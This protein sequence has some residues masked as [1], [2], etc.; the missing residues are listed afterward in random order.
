MYSAGLKSL[1]IPHYEGLIHL[2]YISVWLGREISLDSLIGSHMG[3]LHDDNCTQNAIY[4]ALGN[5]RSP[6]CTT[7][8]NA[9]GHFTELSIRVEWTL[10]AS[11][12]AVNIPLQRPSN[13]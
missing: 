9:T 13:P 2:F 8:A 12:T 10:I 5:R 7:I 6:F 3:H 1:F 11:P 4:P